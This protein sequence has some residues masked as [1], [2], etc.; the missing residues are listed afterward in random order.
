MIRAIVADDEPLSR[1]AVQQLL[2]RHRDVT[3][4]AECADGDATIEAV[5]SYDPDVLFLDVQMPLATGLDV[6]RARDARTGPLVVFVSAFD[7]FALS[8]FEVDAVDY[9]VKPL[10]EERFDAAI[11]RV[12]D[13]LRGRRTYAQHLVS[14]VG[15]RDVILS[16]D[17]VDAIEADDV[18]AAVRAHGK[19]YLVRVSLDKLEESLDPSV[20]ARV[21]RSHIVRLSR[22]TSVR[23]DAA[24]NLELVLGDVVV[25]V[26][27]RRR[28]AIEPLLRPLA[29]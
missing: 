14:H 23:R 18:Y 11:A 28:P 26:S 25:P 5:G 9:V 19:R 2:A 29:T 13:R 1:R 3:V 10:M 20:F 6:A 22:V 4:V 21:H 24:G 8:A 12:R 27:R 15:S 7:E 16:L 17:A